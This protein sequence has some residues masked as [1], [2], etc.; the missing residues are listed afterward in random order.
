MPQSLVRLAGAVRA[1]ESSYRARQDVKGQAID[2]RPAAVTFGESACRDH[3]CDT[4]NGRPGA[5]SPHRA[6][7][8]DG[9]IPRYDAA[10]GMPLASTAPTLDMV[11][12]VKLRN[13][14]SV[15]TLTHI[16]I[17]RD[18][19]PQWRSATRRRVA[20]AA[21]WGCWAL[22]AASTVAAI[23]V[24][25]RQNG[26]GPGGTHD[27]G[28]LAVELTV[29]AAIPL[30]ARYALAGW[31]I[32]Y[33]GVLVTPLIPGQSRA[34]GGLYTVLAIT[35]VVA[36]LRYG[37][38]A[39]S[40][41]AALSLIPVWLWTGPDLVYPARV[42]I[43]L[44][45]L[46]AA[47]YAAG[48]RDRLAL[49]SQARETRKQAEEAR[50]HRERSAFLEERARIAR[51][52]H[53]VVAHHM[54]MIAVQ[55]ETA[56]YRV[57]GLPESAQAEFAA[58]SQ[59]ARAALA[60][61]RR[62]L[63]VLRSTDDRGLRAPARPGRDSIADDPTARGTDPAR[64]RG[65]DAYRTRNVQRRDQHQAVHRRADHQD[66]RRPH[67]DETSAARPGTGSG[68]RLRVRPGHARRI[69]WP[70]RPDAITG[71][72]RGVS[73]RQPSGC[74]TTTAVCVRTTFEWQ[75]IR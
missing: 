66:P 21:A 2:G 54:S 5:A 16:L 13:G 75:P 9:I 45:F 63:G 23:A 6:N 60:D 47:L 41:M 27:W 11:R 35:F 18:E 34:D 67:P 74:H 25:G 20:Y 30:A 69:T 58:L 68:L 43:G 17:G 36:G 73:P 61:M 7:S 51:E 22:L 65:T 26:T 62:L 70:T 37:A 52:M 14:G 12:A 3:A 42:T 38:A 50:Q 57:A 48:R 24:V 55:A 8:R 1:Q 72:A 56:P 10:G 46:T 53:D 33:L 40:W 32:A 59:S 4:M 49:A 31:R 39:L 28:W 29:C 64:G 15:T 19:P 71:R 44:A